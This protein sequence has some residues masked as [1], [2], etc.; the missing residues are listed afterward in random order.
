MPVYTSEQIA[1]VILDDGQ[2]GGWLA[3]DFI[4]IALA[5]SG[6]NAHAVHVVDRDPAS[7]AYLSL[8]LGMWQINTY[9]WPT[10][11]IADSLTP[12]KQWVHVRTLSKHSD[13]W[14]YKL[15]LWTTWTNGR[16][17]DFLSVAR[18]AWNTVA[19]TDL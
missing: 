10:V 2:V 12:E 16:A 18:K 14:G 11:S 7:K 3:I 8:D 1:K 6:G 4:A 17:Y 15:D 19:G 5:E 13:R 9:W